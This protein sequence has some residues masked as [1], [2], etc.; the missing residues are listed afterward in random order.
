MNRMSRTVIGLLVLPLLACTVLSVTAGEWDS[1]ISGIV[2]VTAT[3]V[4][5]GIARSWGS[6]T[7]TLPDGSQHRFK[8]NGLDAVAVGVKQ[9][10]GLGN[11]YHLKRLAD[12][13]GKYVKAIAGGTV[14]G[15]ASST[16][17]RNDKGV[18]IYLTGVGQGMDFQSAVS[19]MD[20][21]LVK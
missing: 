3:S 7:L 5:T 16:A 8:V 12:F 13:N 6:G 20:V 18:V 21:T 4:A 11:V 19:G 9:A 14:R 15:G 10:S 17:M 1:D 2:T